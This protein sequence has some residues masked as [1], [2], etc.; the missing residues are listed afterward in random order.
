MNFNPVGV[1]FLPGLIRDPSRYPG[2]MGVPGADV[3]E[4][5]R[6]LPTSKTLYVDKGH[7]AANDS[8]DGTDP[9]Y[10]LLTIQGAVNKLSNDGDAIVVY[11]GTYTES[12]VTLDSVP[13]PNYVSIIGAGPSR[14]AV[15][16][17]TD[18]AANPALT[19]NAIGWRVSGFRFGSIALSTAAAVLLSNTG[20]NVADRSVIDNC[21]FDGGG[22]GRFGIQ[23]IGGV[24][25]VWIANSEFTGHSNAFAGG[26]V[27]VYNVT[28]AVTRLHLINCLFQENENHVLCGMD[29]SF[30]LGNVF[31]AQGVVPP[32]LILKTIEVGGDGDDN[33]V[34]GNTMPGDYSI[35]GGYVS[36]ATDAWLGNWADDVAELE[37]GDNGITIAIPA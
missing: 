11:P 22:I 8:N 15:Y 23:L 9:K 24:S 7:A 26:A 10:P 30:V 25:D 16:W 3:D 2:Q 34:S 33:V 18:V 19:L 1:P 28:S 17:K 32:T 4:G 37:V 14:H 21:I 6:L 35:V 12:V 5:L 13:G 27:A 36:A 29:S 20:D 31:L